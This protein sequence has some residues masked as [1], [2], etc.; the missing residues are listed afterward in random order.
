MAIN[1]LMSQIFDSLT[2]KLIQQRN[3]THDACRLFSRSPSRGNL[4]RLTNLFNRCGAETFIEQGFYCDYG[5]KISLGDRVFININCTM[6]DAGQI[7]IGDDCLIGPNVQ[8]LTVTHAL[9]PSERLNKASYKD[10]VNIGNNVWLGA[11]VIV[12][13]GIN[14]ADGA[15][16][17]AGSIVTKDVE[18]C[19][20]YLGNP[21]QKI[22]QL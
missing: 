15:V 2:P 11:G 7:I 4:K 5:D 6:L 20:L 9:S 16:I 21:A 1:K 12:L 18:A 3:I 8:I 14:I 10:D 19:C 17:G 22:R 13:P